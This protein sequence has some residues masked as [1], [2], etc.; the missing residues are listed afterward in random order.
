MKVFSGN[1]LL[2]SNNV[3]VKIRFLILFILISSYLI[4]FVFKM[5]FLISSTVEYYLCN[6]F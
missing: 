2:L 6:F 3:N 4:I 1:S 5:I